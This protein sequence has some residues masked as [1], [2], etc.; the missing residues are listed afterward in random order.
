MDSKL[1][2]CK[3]DTSELKYY[4][5]TSEGV[6][7]GLTSHQQQ[8]HTEMEPPFNVSSKGSEQKQ[9]IALAIPG[10]VV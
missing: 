8:D 6:N 4:L 10:L 3:K 1:S 7:S 9:G 5:Y 2:C